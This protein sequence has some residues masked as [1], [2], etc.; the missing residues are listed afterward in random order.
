MK[1]FIVGLLLFI[2]GLLCGFTLFLITIFREVET[3]VILSMYF[4]YLVSIIGL[5]IC[6]KDSYVKKSK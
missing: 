5:I 4:Y 3:H 2:A 1:K 6:I